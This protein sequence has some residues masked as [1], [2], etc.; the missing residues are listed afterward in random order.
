MLVE[1]TTDGG[2]RVDTDSSW[3]VA[4]GRRWTVVRWLQPSVSESWTALL[5]KYGNIG[6]VSETW[7]CA[8]FTGPCSHAFCRNI[9]ASKEEVEVGIL[10]TVS[11]RRSISCRN[12]KC[13]LRGAVPN[14]VLFAAKLGGSSRRR[15]GPWKCPGV[16]EGWGSNLTAKGDAFARSV[17]EVRFFRTTGSTGTLSP[18][19]ALD[20]NQ[21]HGFGA[22][23]DASE[24]DDDN[25][26]RNFFVLLGGYGH[27][28]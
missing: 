1:V 26:W 14:R 4:D 16:S 5:Q 6:K 24:E 15:N 21:A 7:Y 3:A 8:L 20:I 23:E 10:Y 27:Q 12:S 13:W 17:S 9:P 28:G 11:G 2:R 18:E 19:S 22:D 25:V